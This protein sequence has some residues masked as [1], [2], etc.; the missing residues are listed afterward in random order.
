MFMLVDH[1]FIHPVG[2]RLHTVTPKPGNLFSATDTCPLSYSTTAKDSPN[3]RLVS[4]ACQKLF[5]WPGS[6]KELR[7]PMAE[8]CWKTMVPAAGMHF[9]GHPTFS[10]QEICF[11]SEFGNSSIFLNNI[12]AKFFIYFET[13]E[14]TKARST[15]GKGSTLHADERWPVSSV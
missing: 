3:S 14:N 8:G 11:Y 15:V 10:L 1:C 2:T 9:W 6:I 12:K 4:P 13:Q 7:P 5:Q